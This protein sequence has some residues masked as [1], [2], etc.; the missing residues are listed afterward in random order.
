LL[1]TAIVWTSFTQA[2]EVLETLGGQL[3]G[4]VIDL[5]LPDRPGEE[6][7]PVIKRMRQDIPI[8]LMSGQVDGVRRDRFSDYGRIYVLSKPFDAQTFLDILR[9][10]END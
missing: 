4:A 9:R 3:D 1:P 6:L 8:I 5:G 2:I 7:I 10:P